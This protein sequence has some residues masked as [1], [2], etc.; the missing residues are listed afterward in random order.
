MRM[1]SARLGLINPK[2]IGNHILP[3]VFVQSRWSSN[4]VVE[5]FDVLPIVSPAPGRVG[6]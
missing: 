2:R 6:E 4:H 1:A 3:E 5:G